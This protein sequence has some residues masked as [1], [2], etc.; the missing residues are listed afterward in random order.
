MTNIIIARKPIKSLIKTGGVGENGGAKGEVKKIRKNTVTFDNQEDGQPTAA[1]TVKDLSSRWGKAAKYIIKGAPPTV[2]EF[3][4]LWEEGLSSEDPYYD[5][6]CR[7]FSYGFFPGNMYFDQHRGVVI[8]SKYVK[9]KVTK[10]GAKNTSA[11]FVC[12]TL[13]ADTLERTTMARNTATAVV[14]LPVEEEEEN[15]KMRDSMLEQS[16]L[17]IATRGILRGEFLVRELLQAGISHHQLYMELKYYLYKVAGILSPL[18]A[19]KLR[20]KEQIK[21]QLLTE[22]DEHG[23]ISW[24]KLH[25]MEKEAY[26]VRYIKG[27]LSE[28][29]KQKLRYLVSWFRIIFLKGDYRVD[30]E[31][32]AI[33]DI[34]GLQFDDQ[35]NII[36]FVSENRK[37]TT[38]D[39]EYILGKFH[40]FQMTKFWSKVEGSPSRGAEED[41][42]E[43]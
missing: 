16:V 41:D 19:N 7:E 13:F 18:D 5:I 28:I 14:H 31:K 43:P 9:K 26:W 10:K 39:F 40:G 17:D 2:K 27:R 3:V 24:K 25:S 38:K 29:S 23:K 12:N 11:E 21:N 22:A 20:E 15:M 8:L 4:P 42:E 6:M 36:S 1:E 37:K 34:P 33:V 30:M 35:G 32:K